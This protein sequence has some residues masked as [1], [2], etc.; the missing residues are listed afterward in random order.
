MSDE[1]ISR[2]VASSQNGTSRINLFTHMGTDGCKL[3]CADWQRWVDLSNSTSGNNSAR[4]AK[5]TRMND[6]LVGRDTESMQ[7]PDPAVSRRK[8]PVCFR[9]D[10]IAASADSGCGTCAF[11]GRV[12]DRILLENYDLVSDAVVFE[13]VG[14]RF[15]LKISNPD[16]GRSRE[17]QIFLRSGSNVAITGMQSSQPLSGITSDAGSLQT[18]RA[19]IR[20]C[21]TSHD[22]CRAYKTAK[23]PKRVLDCA[24]II[25]EGEPGI[26]L[27]ED[28]DFSAKYACLSHCWGTAP[29]PVL[30]KDKTLSEN[31]DF[32]AWSRLPKTFQDA[33]TITRELGLQYLW[34]DSLCIIQDS[35]E[36]WETESSKMA[37]IYRHG[38]ITIA[39]LSSAD[40]QGGCFPNSPVRDLCLDMPLK[41]AMSVSLGVREKSTDDFF[42]QTPLLTRAWVYQERMLSRRTLLCHYRELQFECRTR[43]MCQCGNDRMAPHMAASQEPQLTAKKDYNQTSAFNAEG[44]NWH[45]IVTTYSKLGITKGRDKLPALSACASD[46]A[47]GR[48]RYLAGLWERTLAEDLLWITEPHKGKLNARPGRVKW[49]APSWSWASMDANPGVQF[50]GTSAHFSGASPALE[51]FRKRIVEAH[52]T[53]AGLNKFGEV[54][55]GYLRV[56][57]RLS[58]AKLRYNCFNCSHAIARMRLYTL[59]S[60]RYYHDHRRNKTNM[61]CSFDGI[62]PLFIPS[63]IRFDFLA[64]SV[65]DHGAAALFDVLGVSYPIASPATGGRSCMLVS[66][67][68]LYMYEVSSTK[69]NKGLKGDSPQ[70]VCF[71]VLRHITSALAPASDLNAAEDWKRDT[72]EPLSNEEQV[73]TLSRICRRGRHDVLGLVEIRGHQQPEEDDEQGLRLQGGVE[74]VVL[75]HEPHGPSSNAPPSTAMAS[76]CLR[77]AT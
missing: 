38:Y 64:D 50:M 55:D 46:S 9:L 36:D 73:I 31:L 60:N 32:I 4:R 68:L 2:N 23:L 56:R 39:A 26:R 18:A 19:W 12:L 37:D 40:H 52:C 67:W 49:R 10:D 6:F 8:N 35:K 57:A 76:P 22:A 25:K 15:L 14:F 77:S 44:R 70:T 28:Q 75:H 3:S 65:L 51:N 53:P 62:E 59:E 58:P 17:F 41:G 30:T 66:A 63:G 21:D 20:H 42:R 61:L 74:V 34:I 45:S 69:G 48:G 54:A 72:I 11:F 43:W 13:W 1:S 24:E 7:Q 29:M 5:H 47:P 33:I 27:M 71:M 16:N